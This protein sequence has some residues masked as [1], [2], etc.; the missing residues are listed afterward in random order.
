MAQGSYPHYHDGQNRRGAPEPRMKRT[1]ALAYRSYLKVDRARSHS[2]LRERGPARPRAVPK[3]RM[4]AASRQL[5]APARFLRRARVTHA[6]SHRGK[7]T[8]PQ[9][10][11]IPFRLHKRHGRILAYIVSKP[12]VRAVVVR[13]GQTGQDQRRKVLPKVVKILQAQHRK[14]FLLVNPLPRPLTCGLAFRLGYRFPDAGVV[15]VPPV[16][17]ICE[18]TSRLRLV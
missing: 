10:D 8:Q 1:R 14:K 11:E 3:R 18:T 13:V 12:D 6:L 7:R 16:P 4:R 2:P 5:S 17:I 15:Q 9:F